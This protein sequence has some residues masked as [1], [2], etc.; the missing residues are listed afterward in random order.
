M[1]FLSRIRDLFTDFLFPRSQ[2]VLALEALS[3]GALVDILP[4]AEHS[5]DPPAPDAGGR[6]GKNVLALFDYSHPLVK[7]IIWELKYG[8]NVR[9]ADKLGEILYDHIQHELQDLTYFEKWSKP[10]LLMPIPIS[11]KRRF[12]RGWNQS[13]LLAEAIMKRDS[14]NLFRYLPRQL[15]KARETESQ[16]KTASRT[17][18]LGNITNSMKVLNAESVGGECVI[19]LD[20]VTTT[21]ST[22]AEARRVLRAAGAKKILCVAVAH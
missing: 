7:E 21:G 2:K 5:E 15:V 1:H 19:V 14:Q 10:I 18:R 3:A 20:D 17:E 22:F 9:I 4:P 6:A 8:G 12:E 11:G 16:T 13:E